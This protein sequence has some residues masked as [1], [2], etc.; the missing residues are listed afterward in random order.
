MQR[1][2]VK[3]SQSVKHNF[4]PIVDTFRT[5]IRQAQCVLCSDALIILSI[6][7]MNLIAERILIVNDYKPPERKA[8]LVGVGRKAKGALKMAIMARKDE[9]N[10]LVTASKTF[11]REMEVLLS[12]DGNIV[13]V[14]DADSDDEDKRKMVDVDTM[15]EGVDTLIYT[16]TI[17]V[18]INCTKQVFDNLFVYTNACS[19][20]LRDSIQGMARMRN[21]NNSDIFLS[22]FPICNTGSDVMS[23]ASLM[24][25]L[26][27]QVKFEKAEI[28][29]YPLG[30]LD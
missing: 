28:E 4:K 8:W 6:S 20:L 19:N 16:S 22:I 25:I 12:E 5:Y 14:I 15:L 30:V 2:S 26:D 7:H 27:G 17:T 23:R 21:F 29:K 9:R 11:A 1:K 18:G 24:S 10:V 13:L 3:H